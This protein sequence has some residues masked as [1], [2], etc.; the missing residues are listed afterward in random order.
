MACPIH[1]H[2]PILC[3]IY[4]YIYTAAGAESSSEDTKLHFDA[5]SESVRF[6]NLLRLS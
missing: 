6:I 5:T 4:I 1:K 2:H 3:Y